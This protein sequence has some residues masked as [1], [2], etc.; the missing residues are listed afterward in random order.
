MPTAKLSTSF[1]LPEVGATGKR[2][3]RGGL[4]TKVNVSAARRIADPA[5]VAVASKPTV[6]LY[7]R[8]AQRRVARSTHGVPTG[9]KAAK[10][11]RL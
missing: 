8:A 6:T 9:A 4:G 7:V 5:F 3:C 11:V 2:R 10:V 1:V